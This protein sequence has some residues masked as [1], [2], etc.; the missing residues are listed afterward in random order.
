[1]IAYFDTSALVALIVQETGSARAQLLWDEAERV[2]AV[3]LVYAEGWAALGMANRTGRISRPALRRALRDLDGCYLQMDIVEVSDDLVRQAGA[4]AE[5]HS[6]RGYDAVHLA[7]A[8][9]LAEDDVVLV[10]GDGP[11]CEAAGRL[12][13]A[14]GRT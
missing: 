1:M 12:G 11:L 13:L 7:A 3:R 8:E 14:V 4:L 5:I 10:A 2:V 6:L 9:T